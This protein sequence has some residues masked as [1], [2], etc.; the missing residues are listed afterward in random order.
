M[1]TYNNKGNSHI[2]I[3]LYNNIFFFLFYFILF[4]FIFICLILKFKNSVHNNN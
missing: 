4:Y 1:N 3:V 2:Y